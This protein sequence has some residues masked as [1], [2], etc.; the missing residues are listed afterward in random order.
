MISAATLNRLIPPLPP[1]GRIKTAIGLAA[2]LTDPTA[3]LGAAGGYAALSN[4]T[5]LGGTLTVFALPQQGANRT[6]NRL[7]A[8][9]IS[10]RRDVQRR[11]SIKNRRR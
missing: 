11:P 10:T 6:V 3:G 7:G 9:N 5:S 1:G 4:C 2:G 8:W